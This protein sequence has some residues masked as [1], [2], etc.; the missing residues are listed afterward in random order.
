MRL[1]VPSPLKIK[2]PAASGPAQ[3]I[4]NPVEPLFTHKSATAGWHRSETVQPRFGLLPHEFSQ[5]LQDMKQFIDSLPGPAFWLYMGLNPFVFPVLNGT[6]TRQRQ[7]RATPVAFNYRH[8]ASSEEK[9][10]LLQATSKDPAYQRDQST[11][12]RWWLISEAAGLEGIPPHKVLGWVLAGLQDPYL[13]VVAASLDSAQKILKNP[14]L[15][16]ELKEHLAGV[17][18]EFPVIRMKRTREAKDYLLGSMLPGFVM[19]RLPKALQRLWNSRLDIQ[20]SE[21]YQKHQAAALKRIESLQ[22]S[23]K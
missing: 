10:A 8:A 7:K 23:E 3:P 1:L 20:F 4:A 13:M 6:I 11:V 2:S 12:T 19:K 9:L 14:A 17:L 18:A 21:A 15:D 16:R 22:A 5:G